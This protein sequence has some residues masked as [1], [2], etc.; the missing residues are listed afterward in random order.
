MFPPIR[1]R[2]IIPSC[3]RPLP[4][5]FERLFDSR[6]KLLEARFHIGRQVHAQQAPPAFCQDPEITPRLRRFHDPERVTLS[7]D[8]EI[9]GIVAGDLQEDAA[10]RPTLIGLPGRMQK[11]RTEAEAGRG[12]G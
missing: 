7:W 8:G 12:P 5:L 9:G 1:P 11:P 10:V 4:D 2:P 6:L 3:M